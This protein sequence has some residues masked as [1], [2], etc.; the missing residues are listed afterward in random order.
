MKKMYFCFSVILLL[1][2][3]NVS[4]TAQ[5]Q[6]YNYNTSGSA[7]S[8]PFNLAGGKE[9]QLLYLAGDFNHPTPIPAGN[10][11]RI[12]FRINDAYPLGPYT[13][14]DFTIKMGQSGITSFSAGSLYTGTL[15]TVY[16][17]ASVSL[18]G[19][20]GQWMEI[21][22]D[23]PFPYDPTQSMILDV[24][25]CGAPGATGYSSCFTTFPENRRIYSAGGC[26]FV[27]GNVTTTIFHIGL[28][29]CPF[30]I[31]SGEYEM[32]AN[33]GSYDYTTEPGMTGYAWTV[34]AGGVIGGGSGTNQISVTWTTPGAQTVS[35]TYSSA[36]CLAPSPTVYN[37][38]VHN[39]P[40]VPGS[41][42]GTD[43]VCP[44][45]GGVAYSVSP[46][47]GAISYIWNLPAGA[48][49]ASGS[50]TNS[51]L[52]NYAFDAVPGAMT[53][54]GNNLCGNS[55][56]S[57]VFN[58]TMKPIPLTPTIM[59]NGFVLTSS[60]PA[61]NQWYMDGSE[62]LGATGQ[63]YTATQPG[64]YTCMVT[65]DGCSSEVSDGVQIFPAGMEEAGIGA[66]ISLYPN[67]GDGL[68]NVMIHSVKP[69]IFAI[70]V[71]N[72]LGVSIREF[73]NIEVKGTFEKTIDLGTCPNGIYFIVIRNGSSQIVKKLTVNK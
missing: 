25:Q 66:A 65:L 30:P 43:S 33:S 44:G 1:A 11:T 53:V 21:L 47:S 3:L 38:T 70:R 4:V 23:T 9:V 28:S 14:T 12:F 15:T 73:D 18:T 22:L 31:I 34:S 50:G 26:P 63:I 69:E 10:I 57:P 67:P 19:I 16:Y 29:I 2:G 13:Y 56:S 62:I 46:V 6:Y 60:A 39:V 61:G 52:V 51:I 35:V 42:T 41:I 68:F 7:N 71:V 8:H 54:I 24:G 72:N 64:T 59:V 20:A 45:A 58:I 36:G 5:P 32:C 27:Y 37:V 48:S 55:P 40:A 17:R 49:A